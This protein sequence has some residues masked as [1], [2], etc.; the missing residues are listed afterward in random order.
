MKNTDF[1]LRSCLP[2]GARRSRRGSLAAT[3]HHCAT[4]TTNPLQGFRPPP[5]LPLFPARYLG[6]NGTALNVSFQRLKLTWYEK[7]SIKRP[8]PVAWNSLAPA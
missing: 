5:P 4:V 8:M 2:D 1:R 7:F 3:T 6:R